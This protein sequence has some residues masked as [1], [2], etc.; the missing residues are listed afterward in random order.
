MGSTRCPRPC[1]MGRTVRQVRRACLAACPCARTGHAVSAAP[2]RQARP[3]PMVR[4]DCPPCRIAWGN[5]CPARPTSPRRGVWPGRGSA[6]RVCSPP[7]RRPP[8]HRPPVAAWGWCPSGPSAR[9]P[10][11]ASVAAGRGCRRTGPP[12]RRLPAQVAGR[13]RPSAV[14]QASAWAAVPVA[15][16][17]RRH[18]N[19]PTH[20]LPGQVAALVAVSVVVVVPVAVVVAV[21]VAEPGCHRTDPPIHRPQAQVVGPAVVS[22]W[23]AVPVAVLVAVAVP[24]AAPGCHRTSPPIRRP[25]AQVPAWLPVSMPERSHRPSVRASVPPGRPRRPPNHP[26]HPAQGPVR[27]RGTAG[28][29]RRSRPPA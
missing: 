20:R 3:C 22:V 21:V 17:E 7:R 11:P 25:P 28:V 27:A 1:P 26:H 24:V 12:T 16:L 8:P 4:S 5:R 15:A 2:A 6:S 10:W 29:A 19:P 13:G 14:V 23:V 18:I 9:H